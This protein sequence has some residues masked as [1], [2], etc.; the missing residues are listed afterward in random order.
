MPDYLLE[1]GT[2]E[3]PAGQIN[4]AQAKLEQLMGEALKSN[5]L[6]FD[7]VKAM[8][9]PRRLV[10]VVKNVQA[11]Q[12]TT[13]NRVKGPKVQQAFGADG[14]PTPQATGFAGKYNL[15]VDQLEK[16]EVGGVEHIFATVTVVGKPAQ[17][18]F[19]EI[20]PALVGQ[21][22]F[23][24]PMCWGSKSMKFS[25]PIRWIVSLLDEEVVEF[26]LE[27]LK[28]GRIT[29][30]HRI[31]SPGDITLKNPGE[32]AEKLKNAK[33]LVDPDERRRAIKE[34]VE[35]RAGE[36]GGEARQLGGS[37]LDEVVNLNEWPHPV[38]GEFGKEYL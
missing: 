25:R 8:S 31:L 10:V 38:V 30:G 4:E 7:S 26:Q 19:Q 29:Q 18:V 6:S 11:K 9:T 37:L 17:E 33:V 3:L 14:K 12:E 24:R 27:G 16:E 13:T 5:S 23:E 36:L 2:E 22:P 28:A 35:K 20:A 21:L 34:S 1:I 32:Y 15:T